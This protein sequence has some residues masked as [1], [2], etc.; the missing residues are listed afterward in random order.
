LNLEVGERER[1]CERERARGRGK[2]SPRARLITTRNFI[3]I[4]FHHV[5]ISYKFRVEKAIFATLLETS[6]RKII[7]YIE[8]GDNFC[9][10]NEI[11]GQLRNKRR[12]D[13][14]CFNTVTDLYVGLD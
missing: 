13:C 9:S 8:E 11:E 10:G 14:S 2:G 3:F 1:E 6:I 7:K 12:K 5:K 4:F